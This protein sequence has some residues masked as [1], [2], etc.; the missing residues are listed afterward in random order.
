MQVRSLGQEDALEEG[1]ATHSSILA[2][3]IPMDRGA[4]WA[5]VHG[6]VESDMTEWLSMHAVTHCSVYLKIFPSSV[7]FW[8]QRAFICD[9]KPINSLAPRIHLCPCQ[10]MELW[11]SAFSAGPMAGVDMSRRSLA[12]HVAGPSL[13]P[14]QHRDCVLCTDW[15]TFQGPQSCRSGPKSTQAALK[16]KGWFLAFQSL[17]DWHSRYAPYQ[18]YLYF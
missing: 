3:R 15:A 16:G 8:D 1:M 9:E 12:N 2:R 4:W 6:V 14:L 18:K 10:A 17:E 5:T 11:P 13:S 7:E